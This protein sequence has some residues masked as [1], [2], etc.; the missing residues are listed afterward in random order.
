MTT[1]AP[2]LHPLVSPGEFDL[3]TL[4]EHEPPTRW[5]PEPEDK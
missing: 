4:L 2:P 1:D 3:P 5:H